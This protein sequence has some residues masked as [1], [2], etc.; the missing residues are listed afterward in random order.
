VA[1]A[2]GIA[3]VGIGAAAFTV[4]GG[5]EEQ[6]PKITP[7]I[8]MYTIEHAITTGDVPIPEPSSGGSTASSRP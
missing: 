6:G 4:G 2:V 8:Q 1:G 5:A 3:V 7:P